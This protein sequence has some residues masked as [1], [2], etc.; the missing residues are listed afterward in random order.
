VEVKLG[1]AVIVGVWLGVV[2]TVGVE[3]S[4]GGGVTVGGTTREIT[5]FR[6]HADRANINVRL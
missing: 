4:T 6:E 3:V 2:T 1:T 5:S